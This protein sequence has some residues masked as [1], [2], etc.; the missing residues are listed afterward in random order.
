MNTNEGKLTEEGEGPERLS[1]RMEGYQS[2][3]I[4]TQRCPYRVE[5]D[6]RTP[7]RTDPLNKSQALRTFRELRPLE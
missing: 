2:P 7:G 3:P 6:L 5:G 1:H 4:L